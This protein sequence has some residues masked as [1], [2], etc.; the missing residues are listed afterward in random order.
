METETDVRK[1]IEFIGDLLL[2]SFIL[3]PENRSD[4]R[5]C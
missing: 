4:C 5:G 3:L 1:L 2:G